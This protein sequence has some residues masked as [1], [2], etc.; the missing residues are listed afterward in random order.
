M[1]KTSVLLEEAFPKGVHLLNSKDPTF[2]RII[3]FMAKIKGVSI[4]D[5]PKHPDYPI[6]SSLCEAYLDQAQNAR[7]NI[8]F[9]IKKYVTT[10]RSDPYNLDPRA[11]T[12]KQQ[13]V[14][15]LKDS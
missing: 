3:R 15:Y 9:E 2:A 7:S 10:S 11:T 4:E 1:C 5:L 8:M 12:R 13:I 14:E 6:T